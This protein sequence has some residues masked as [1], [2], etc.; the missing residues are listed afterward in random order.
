MLNIKTQKKIRRH[1]RIRAKVAGTASRPRLSVFKSNMQIS[2]QL[3]DDENG[4]T[5]GAVND[6]SAKGKTKTERAHEAGVQIAKIAKDKKI[7]TVVFDRGGYI[8]T[9][10]VKAFA[11]GAREGGLKF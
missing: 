8:F 3:I 4:V 6:K 10:R 11:E 2:A 5:L 7:D 9:G 1:A